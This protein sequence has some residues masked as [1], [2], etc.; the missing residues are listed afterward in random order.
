MR[1]LETSGLVDQVQLEEIL[2]PRSGIVLER[3]GTASGRFD[4][5]EGPFHHYQRTVAVTD[6]GEG[7]FSVDQRV[8]VALAVPYWGW[9]FGPPI[10]RAL[11]HLGPVAAGRHPWWAP[12][13]RLD[14]EAASTLAA[15]ALLS[16]ILGYAT[17]LISQTITFAAHEFGTGKTAQGV[18]LAA[19]RFDLLLSFP[20]VTLTDRR[21][22]RRL[23][24]V[25]SVAAC[26]ATAL[27]AVTPSLPLFIATQVPA[28][29][30][31][32]AAGVIVSI[33][34]AEEMPAGA[35]AYAISLL[36]SAGALGA[37]LAIAL[38]PLA[39]VGE[40][41]WR[42]LFAVGLL[43]VFPVIRLARHL[44]E[45]RRFRVPHAEVS[46]A[47]HGRRLWLLAMS[48]LLIA[49]FTTP[50][51]WFLN[52]YLRDERGF[53]A[54]R[55]SL[56]TVLTGIPGGLG[57]V[58]GG[59]LADTRGRRGVGAIAIVAG[60]GATT[61]MFIATGWPIWAW[62]AVGS[63][64]GAATVPAL[65]VY[66]PELF[67]TSLRGKANALIGVA[68]RIGSVTGLIA[69]GVI[70]TSRN[71]GQAMALMAI[72]PMALAILIIAVYPETAHRALEELNPEDATDTGDAERAGD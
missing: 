2:T 41:G 53:S 9:L 48:G 7:R 69:V 19:V 30:L 45:S 22:R 10:R 38:L 44:P 8:E 37:G 40:G 61:L 33:V 67:P 59:R 47:G 46:L 49:L 52:E 25:A 1:V 15:L 72:G 11:R 43:G 34:A 55:I 66:G 57:I 35:R 50:A 42:I 36:A 18:A 31:L 63:V 56:F 39:D 13:D 51:G 28:R 29:G 26:I 58:I 20:L 62:S 68:G 14:T 5:E 23:L 64:L 3:A 70:A 12:P 4:L 65:G 16:V 32:T 17:I 27:T 60:V 71:F 21:G 6:A 24:L 54:A